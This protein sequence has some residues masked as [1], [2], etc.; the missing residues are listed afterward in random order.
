MTGSKNR[1]ATQIKKLNEKYLLIHATALNLDIRETIKII[2]LLKDKLYMAYEITKLIKK[3]P[4]RE[5]EFHRKQPEFMGQ[6]ERDFHVYNI[7][8]P[9]LK[10]LYPTSRTV[11]A[12]C[13]S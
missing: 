11:R 7:Y 1:V 5:A 8:S 2:S 3:S 12:S 6:M 13:M 9:T 4:K 10:I